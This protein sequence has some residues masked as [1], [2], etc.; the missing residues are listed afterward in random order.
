MHQAL[1]RKWR[2]K[3]F[4]DVCGQEHITSV[5]SWQVAN[6][7]LSHAYL[8]C[9]SRGTGK[10]TCAKI[11]AKAANC[12]NT[13]NGNPCNACP[14]CAEI[15]SGRS[16][17]VLEMD[18]ASNTG[19]DYIRD[20]REEVIFTPSAMGTRVYIID[21][22]HMLSEGAFN[23]LLKTL[24]EPPA[25]VIFILATTEM[26]EIPATILSRC[27]R[28]DFRRIPLQTIMD[29]LL[30]IAK[31]ESIALTD[32]GARLIA[33]LSQGGMR[34]AISLLELCA[35][36]GKTVNAECVSA[37]AGV[38]GRTQVSEAVAAIAGKNFAKILSQVAAMYRS[39]I[40]L[41]VFF[42]DLITYYR[43]MMV[44]KA[45]K[46]TAASGQVPG[47]VLDYSDSELN[48]LIQNASAF[49]YQ[50]LLY[51]VKLLEEAFLSMHRGEDKRVVA[52]MTLLRLC[53]GAFGDSPE[54][55]SARIAELEEKLTMLIAGGVAVAAPTPAAVPVATPK[56]ASAPAIPEAPAKK[57][58]PAVQKTAPIYEAP[59]APA[60]APVADVKDAYYGW[61]D[62][63]ARYEKI[64]QGGAPFLRG[65]KVYV[66]GEKKLHVELG[67][68]FAK[69]LLES[70]SAASKLR[71]IA[72]SQGD[73]FTDVVIEIAKP[74]TNTRSA[75]DDLF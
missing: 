51:H 63:V 10:T 49:N 38:C 16:L 59:D 32:D 14:I 27:Q 41:S 58:A 12:P 68:S 62:L 23:A 71:A 37:A 50:T 47:E 2:P 35:G 65:A 15:D 73:A 8:F 56:V 67:D 24:E 40:D 46:I 22:V 42:T 44:Q 11:L 9:G 60:P 29:R 53:S 5:L 19:V 36:E 66:D 6:H 55:L 18:A 28:F 34:D 3:A 31:S 1:Y 26:Q 54:A 30:Y 20:I 33:R 69:R 70:V 45:L 17:E 39:S 21:E 74:D 61:T 52:E 4:S 75:F 64:D 57:S 25:G 48:E 13:V 43:D 72:Q 7:K